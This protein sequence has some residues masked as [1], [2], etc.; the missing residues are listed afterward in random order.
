VTKILNLTAYNAI[1]ATRICK[2]AR[3]FAAKL[4]TF[5]SYSAMLIERMALYF[6]QIISVQTIA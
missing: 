3:E 1:G 6:V 4:Q 2:I 5:K